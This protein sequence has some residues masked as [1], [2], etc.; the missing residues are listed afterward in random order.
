MDYCT[1]A[2]LALHNDVGNTHLPAE[3]REVDNQL[4]WV[5]IMSNDDQGCLLSLDEGDGMVEAVLDEY[6]FLRFLRLRVGD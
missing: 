3:G 2:G 5:N 4:N 6:R 1:K